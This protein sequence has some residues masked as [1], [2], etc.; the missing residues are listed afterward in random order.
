MIWSLLPAALAGTPVIFD[1]PS[2]GAVL[3]QVVQR[4]G[5]PQ[6]QL[7]PIALRDLI[8]APPAALGAAVIRHCAGEPVTMPII[9][10]ELVRAEGAW[11][12]GDALTAMDHLDLAVAWLSCLNELGD[13]ATLGRLFLL[14]GALLAESGR[15]DDARAELNSAVAFAPALAWQDGFPAS[16]E[17]LLAAVVGSEV[18]L[19]ISLTPPGSSS[20]PWI[21]GHLVQGSDVAV[22]RGLHLIQVASTAGIRSA[23]LF[24]SE[25]AAL[26]I[27]SSYH[28]SVLARIQDDPPSTEL[29]ALLLGTDPDLT[30]AYVAY[31]S[32]LWLVIIEDGVAS[33]SMLE[34]PPPPPD[35][36]TTRKWWR[37]WK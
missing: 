32:G 21:D 27:P 26:V 4:T 7:E 28:R 37:F 34:A 24:V 35:P 14:R 11:H 29:I 20:G 12:Q 2:S 19:Q 36:T 30:A 23:W 16:G 17:A 22:R 3:D 10:T 15:E 9:Q 18:A 1:S 5:L 13:S 6:D 8:A 31:N 25:D 33:V